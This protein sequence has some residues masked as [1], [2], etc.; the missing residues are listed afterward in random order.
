MITLI[1]IRSSVATLVAWAGGCAGA[2]IGGAAK[3][4]L[5]YL[6]TGALG[7][8]LAVTLFDILPDAY[9]LLTV[10]MFIIA[11]ASGVAL[12]W[13]VGK[14]I[15]PVCPA[16][17][18]AGNIALPQV[19]LS[20]TVV[21]LAIAL[22][23]HSTMDGAAVVIGDTLARGANAG[24]FFAVSLHKFP[25]GL[26]LCLLLIGAGISRS[27]ALLFT[28]G[29]EAATELGAVAALLLVTR[30]SRPELGL[31]FANIAGGFLYL[32][33]STLILESHQPDLQ[34]FDRRRII[35]A[36]TGSIG[37]LATCVVILVGQNLAH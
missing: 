6:V 13:V 20:R 26:A 36:G 32:V 5:T 21:L 33:V 27:R 22:G 18:S 29:I 3:S 14:Y 34:K 19:Q 15:Y 37:F 11:V 24:V 30:L 31:I 25:E 35:S 1:L 8:L 4:R 16:C 17:S 10:P 12:F 23:V 7:A 2:A 9:R 28:I